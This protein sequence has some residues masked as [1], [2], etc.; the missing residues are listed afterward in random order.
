MENK[1]TVSVGFTWAILLMFW[2]F[3]GQSGWYRVDCAIGIERA[4]ELITVERE[5]TR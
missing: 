3:W 4:C 1:V 5:Y 2:M